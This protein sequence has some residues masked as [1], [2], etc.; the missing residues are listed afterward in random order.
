MNAFHQQPVNEGLI[1]VRVRTPQQLFDFRD[2]AP[3]NERDLDDDFVE[4]LQACMS[5]IPMKKQLKISISIEKQGLEIIPTDTIIH[6][7]KSYYTFQV[8]LAQSH[9]KNLFKRSQL[10]LVI[11]LIT[12]FV[13]LTGAQS[14]RRLATEGPF[15][16][17]KEGLVIFGWVSM[18]K[19]VELMMFD[20]IPIYEKI[21]TLK[22]ILRSEIEV[23]FHE[24][25]ENS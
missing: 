18:W 8:E 12:L 22:K 25:R 9:L 21:N 15:A 20:W 11:G 10:F 4:Y 19:P 6:A 1:E 16:I 13:C 5:E 17:L 3:F 7:I 14:L 2:P 23:V 24:A